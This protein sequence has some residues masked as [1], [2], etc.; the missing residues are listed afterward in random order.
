MWGRDLQGRDW[1]ECIIYIKHCVNYLC[2]KNNCNKSTSKVSDNLL[3]NVHGLW[4]PFVV[5]HS[6]TIMWGPSVMSRATLEDSHIEHVDRHRPASSEPERVKRAE[7]S[8]SGRESPAA[9]FISPLP[10]RQSQAPVS[11]IHSQDTIPPVA[12][13]IKLHY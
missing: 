2:Y 8:E 7:L 4:Q 6:L 11:C 12:A 3:L 5:L 9:S 10:R 13:N 1:C